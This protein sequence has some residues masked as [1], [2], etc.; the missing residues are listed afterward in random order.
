MSALERLFSHHCPQHGDLVI[1]PVVL[2]EPYPVRGGAWG[3]TDRLAA[4]QGEALLRVDRGSPRS[5]AL[6]LRGPAPLVTAL[7]C[8]RLLLA[9]ERGIDKQSEGDY[10]ALERALRGEQ[11]LLATLAHLAGNPCLSGDLAHEAAEA[12]LQAA[13][14]AGLRS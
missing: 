4:A 13:R 6:W 1:G 11:P 8:L 2:C 5:A 7:D 12:L 10:Q 3:T 14:D 9:K